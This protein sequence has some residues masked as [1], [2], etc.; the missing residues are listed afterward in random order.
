[1]VTYNCMVLQLSS[2]VEERLLLKTNYEM[3]GSKPCDSTYDFNF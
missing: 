2:P 3:D 1:M